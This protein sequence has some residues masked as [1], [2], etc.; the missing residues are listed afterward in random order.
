MVGADIGD[1][2][3]HIGEL[4]ADRLQAGCHIDKGGIGAGLT[5]AQER[6]DAFG[7]PP[8]LIEVE[9]HLAAQFIVGDEFAAQP[10]AGDRRA[11]IVA[12][13]RQH[14]GAVVDQSADSVAH[15]IE[16][17]GDGAHFLRSAL[18]Q[19]GHVAV[20]A[21]AFGRRGESGQ[22]PPQGARRPE[23]EQRN[24]DDAKQNRHGHGAAEHRRLAARR[25]QGGHHAAIRHPDGK[26]EA[27]RIA[28][29]RAVR[30]QLG[31]LESRSERVRE[32]AQPRI[33]LLRDC[34]RRHRRC[35]RHVYLRKG[36]GDLRE[37]PVA[38]GGR[39]GGDDLDGRRELRRPFVGRAPITAALAEENPG[40]DD[41]VN[42]EQRQHQQQGHLAADA[43][44][45]QRTD[46][47][48]AGSTSGVNK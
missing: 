33:G 22:R 7:H 17:L 37:Q 19:G 30:R 8:H 6:Q 25:Q 13:G 20:Q 36:F 26:S 27:R 43:I 14:A 23:A 9:Q 15:P 45:Q 28:R 5:V 46:E 18:R 21:E 10:Q 29:Q 41:G 31:Q 44:E 3:S 1:A 47:G 40:R 48:H 38:L 4:V 16:R 34:H 11:Q 2:A 39:R 42:G 32:E 24:R 12:H 35:R